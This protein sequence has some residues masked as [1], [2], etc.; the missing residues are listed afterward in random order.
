MR[1]KNAYDGQE[2]MA[3]DKQAIDAQMRRLYIHSGEEVSD[4]S[5][6]SF[7]YELMRDVIPPGTVERILL[8]S[9]RERTKF[10]NG[11]LAQYAKDVAY[12]LREPEGEKR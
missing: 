11:Y 1:T 8:N 12:R 5:L 4:D 7:L 6:V 10:T 2:A 9:P 3:I